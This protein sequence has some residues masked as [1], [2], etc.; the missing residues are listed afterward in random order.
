MSYQVVEF[1]QLTFALLAIFSAFLG[2]IAVGWWRWGRPEKKRAEAPDPGEASVGSGLFSAHERAD[3]LRDRPV[4]DTS[5]A[6]Q[7][8]STDRM[9]T[10]A[11]AN[12]EIGVGTD[13]P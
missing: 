8:A 1:V 7:V 6:G 3:E 4:F 9:P 10:F 5:A 11:A 12:R 2:G 13:A